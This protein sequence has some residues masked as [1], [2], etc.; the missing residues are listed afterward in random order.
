VW[1]YSR[2][3]CHDRHSVQTRLPVEEDSVSI[4]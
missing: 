1:H 3:V 4:F 2:S